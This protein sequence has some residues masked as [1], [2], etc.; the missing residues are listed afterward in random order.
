MTGGRPRL[1]IGTFGT[2]ELSVQSSG[3]RA[4]VWVRDMDGKRR[5]VPATASSQRKAEAALKVKLTYRPGYG[6]AGVLGVSSSFGELCELWLDDLELRDISEG[7]KENYRD[8]LRLHVHP[9]FENYSL[10]EITTGRVEW[11]LKN[12]A[13][14]SYSRAKHSRTL[15]SQLIAFALRHDALPRNPLEGT[16]QLKPPKRTIRAMTLEQVQQIRAAGPNV[17]VSALCSRQ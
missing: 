4:R 16:S 3:W 10:G 15:L 11:F 13:A 8:D 1:A 14:V 12:E 9:A 5:R 6:G 2:I 7:T 17:Q